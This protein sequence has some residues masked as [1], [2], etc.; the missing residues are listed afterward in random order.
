MRRALALGLIFVFTSGCI[1]FAQQLSGSWD[2]EIEIDPQQVS[3]ADSLGLHSILK[4]N[5]TIGDWTFG[6]A[7]VL[8]EDGWVDQDFST[9]G[10]LG[11]YTLTSAVDFNPDATFGSLV[12]T[13]SVP[14]AGVL[15]GTQFTLQ[16]DDTFFI[17]TASGSS[18]VVNITITVNFG[19]DD[20]VCDFPFDKATISVGFPFCC[21]DISSSLIIGCEGFDQIAFSTSGI[22][23]P[24][25]PWLSIG[26]QLVYTLQ[27]KS[28][29][30]SP[31]F[32]FATETCIDFYIQVDSSDNLTIGDISIEGIKLSCDVGA[33][34]FTGITFW[35]DG[36]KPGR[37]AGTDY[38]EVYTIET[39]VDA[40]CGPL[41]FDVSVFFLENGLR[42]FDVSLFE[43]NLELTVAPQFTFSTGLEIDVE[44]N[45]TTLWTLGFEIDW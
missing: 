19:D 40:C 32:N 5:Y 31:T 12:V 41:S 15:L 42:L 28:L 45:A 43:A 18:G 16:G 22:A 44:V 29:T 30:L 17:F 8:A 2:L 36:S 4:V 37:L 25:L 23:I 1:G 10:L 7:T 3:F 9:T 13:T 39:N 24:N 20:A 11:P 27:T 14:F 34:T 6:T 33:V 35:G 38:W 26:V 21:A